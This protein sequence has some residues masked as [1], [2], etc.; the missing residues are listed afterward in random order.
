MSN[1]L[2]PQSI[3]LAK[4]LAGNLAYRN[5]SSDPAEEAGYMACLY[6]LYPKALV[7]RAM[8]M[9]DDHIWLPARVPSYL[10]PGLT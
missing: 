8:D 4:Q 5:L 7:N 10:Q 6:D 1:L 3:S 2:N 9:Y